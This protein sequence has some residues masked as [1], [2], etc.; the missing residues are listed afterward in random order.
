MASKHSPLTPS[1]AASQLHS[2]RLVKDTSNPGQNKGYGTTPINT[3][4]IQISQSR[5]PW[6]Q[7]QSTLSP[8]SDTD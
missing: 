6:P 5:Q 4:H 8:S 1:H 7:F 2:L 3:T